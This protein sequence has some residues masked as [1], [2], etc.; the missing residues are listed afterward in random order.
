MVN[1]CCEQVL[2]G[3]EDAMFDQGELCLVIGDSVKKF[4]GYCVLEFRKFVVNELRC[5]CGR[6]DRLT[7]EADAVPVFCLWS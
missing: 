7:K 5:E 6:S 2:Y 4:V 1:V 3:W